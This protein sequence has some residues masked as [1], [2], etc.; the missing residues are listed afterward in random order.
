MRSASANRNLSDTLSRGLY[1]FAGTPGQGTRQP[2]ARTVDAPQ[3]SGVHM[4]TRPG[5]QRCGGVGAGG[6]GGA[7]DAGGPSA[8]AHVA[9]GGHPASREAD[10]AAANELLGGVGAGG[11]GLAAGAGVSCG[12]AAPCELLGG[13]GAC[14]GGGT[15]S[16]DAP[17][18]T[19][20][21]SSRD[22]ND[23]AHDSPSELLA[24]L[25]EVGMPNRYYSPRHTSIIP[26][27]DACL[28]LAG[29]SIHLIKQEG[30]LLTWGGGAYLSG[31]R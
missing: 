3:D 26:L 9:V 5:K 4:E 7:A 17:G 8:G 29:I 11:S 16:A 30:V 25:L 1:A 27:I 20:H 19:Q 13:G 22:E 2:T 18:R 14:G 21:A 28:Y 23:D 6:G 24:P 15:A 31:P 10:D 12:V